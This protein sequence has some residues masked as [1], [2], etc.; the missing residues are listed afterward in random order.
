MKIF[1]D[2]ANIQE[3]KEA[4]QMGIIDG[5]TTNPTLLAKESGKG[6]QAIASEII[7]LVDGPISLEVISQKAEEMLEE[8]KRLYDLSHKHVVIK[9]PM[10]EEGLL[11]YEKLLRK[12]L[13]TGLLSICWIT[14]FTFPNICGIVRSEFVQ[15]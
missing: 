11:I 3:I 10:C 5:I 9:V 12:E 1:L 6:L 7:H 13:Y 15:T 8:G 4:A 2:T 14:F